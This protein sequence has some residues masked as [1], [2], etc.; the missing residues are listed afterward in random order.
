M[1]VK[2]KSQ[3]KIYEGKEKVIH[4]QNTLIKNWDGLSKHNLLFQNFIL[5]V[6][7]GN[8]NK[9]NEILENLNIF[10]IHAMRNKLEYLLNEC[11][12]RE[13]IGKKLI[14]ILS[15]GGGKNKQI[16]INQNVIKS[17]KTI[18][19]HLDEHLEKIKNRATIK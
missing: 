11:I 14:P 17:I 2:F 19:E 7:S 12:D 6:F 16:P 15:C 13:Q 8:Q 9:A 3:V 18:K 10:G 5:Y 4:T 1:K